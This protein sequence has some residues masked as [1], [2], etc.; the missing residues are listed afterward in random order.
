MKRLIVVSDSHGSYSDLQ[1][2]FKQALE[3]GPID[4]AIHLGDGL[5]D[6]ERVSPMLWRNGTACCMVAGNNDYGFEEPRERLIRVNGVRIFLCHGHM[7]HVK[8][9]LQTLC[10]AAMEKEASIALYGHT[11]TAHEE[12]TNGVLLLNPGAVCNRRIGRIAYAEILIS[13]DQSFS[14]RLAGWRQNG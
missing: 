4:T 13:E 10:Y 7:L 1:D 9:G 14:W 2:A 3:D 8:Y 5:S 11:H 12:M 6:F